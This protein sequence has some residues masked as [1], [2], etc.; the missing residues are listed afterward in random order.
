MSLLTIVLISAACLLAAYFSYGPV[1]AR[2]LKLR[3]DVPTPAVTM[4]DDVDYAP[5]D[6]KFLLSQHFS[7][8]AAAGPIV[9][10]ILAGITFG[11]LPALLWILCGSILIGGVH[12]MTALTASI[13][14][15]AR[16]IAEVVRDHMSR[17]SYLLFLSFVWLALVY[18]IVAFTDVTATSFLG[19]LTLDDGSVATAADAAAEQAASAPLPQKITGGGIATSSL[20]YLALPIIM[21][22]LLKFTRLTVNWATVIF[23]PLVGL[24][25]WVGQYFP[26]DIAQIW[27]LSPASAQKA[28]N[29]ALVIYCV[30][31]SVL[32]M[33][34]LLQ[35]RGHLG[36]YF[37]YVA[38][39][40]G[41]LGL[42][43]GGQEI[44]Y[45]AFRDW[46]VNVKGK[47]V[48][49][50]AML[51]ITIACGACS[52]FHSIIASGTTSKQLRKETDARLIGYGSML[53]EAM[54]AIVSLCCVMML[55][56]GDPNLK[57][58]PNFLYARGIGEFLRVIKISPSFGVAFGLMA[59]TTFVYDTLDVCTRLGRYILQELTGLHG[60]AGRWLATALTAGVPL[61][62]LIW[63]PVDADGK[64]VER[65]RIFWDLF[66]ASNQ[67]L[68]ALTLLGV[69]VW[70]YNTYRAKWVF[71]V[72]GLP[73]VFMYT[74]SM[75]ALVNIVWPLLATLRD[76][77]FDTSG[78]FGNPVPWVALV[79][80]TLGLLILAEA[81]R[82]VTGGIGGPP[83]S[84]TS[85]IAVPTA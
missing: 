37:L 40:G 49:L 69:T 10:P 4:R 2:L 60:Q 66:G 3:D 54:V 29:V 39:A 79:L 18:I 1:L 36:G 27:N 13:R 67:L 84:E 15:K 83:R 62:F 75:W 38:L 5:I 9:G 52:G 30:I 85:N 28:W 7:A 73:C 78:P 80:A 17:R 14:H 50:F 33:W 11:W 77:N 45:P 51:F 42:I 64:V 24:A 41:M 57:K 35:P 76:A 31:A 20:L 8:I 82:V 32:P 6:S 58:G 44:Q 19:E 23:V 26:F 55:V 68:A 47:D 56:D 61:I 12:D 34:L 46:T 43:L 70:L 65:W 74:M 53:L 63:Q 22:L 71:F 16:S 21:G 48:S 59:F 81:V 25:I 72:T